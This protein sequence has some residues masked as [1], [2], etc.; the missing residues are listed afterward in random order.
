MLI[1]EKTEQEQTDFFERCF[2]KFH[3]ARTAVGVVHYDYS[4]AGRFIRLS[5]A[6][7][8]LVPLI[9]AALA[10]LQVAAD[11]SPDLTICIWDSEST[12]VKMEP[13][14]CDRDCFTDRG[15]VWGF[16][17]RKIKTAFHWIENSVNV[18][19]LDKKVGVFWVQTVASLPFWV[20]ASPLRTQFHWWMETNNLQLLHAAAVGTDQGGVLI[21]GKG[22]VGKS[23]TAL[24]CLTAGFNYAADDYL[25]V[26]ADPEP[27]AY[28]LYCT[29]KVNAEDV[30]R[31][32]QYGDAIA[33]AGSLD[34]EKAVMFLYPHLAGQLQLRMPLKAV[35]TPRITHEETTRISPAP[36]WNIQRAMAFTTMSQLPGVGRHTH[37]FINRFCAKLPFYHLFL[38]NRLDEIPGTIENFLSSSPPDEERDIQEVSISRKTPLVTAIIPVYN[39]ERFTERTLQHVVSQNYPAL[40]IIVVDDGSTDATGDIV[41]RMDMD[42]RYFRQDNQGPASARNRGL[43]DA[44]GEYIFFLDVDDYWPENNIRLLVEQIHADDHLD[45]VRGYAQLVFED[46]KTGDV[47]FGGNPKES[48]ADYIGAAVYRK[49]VFA[50]VGL[51]DPTLLFGEDSDWF[52]RARECQIPMKRIEDTTLYV[53][54]HGGNMTRGKDLV[55]LNVLHVFKKAL[56][57]RR[58]MRKQEPGR[59]HGDSRQDG[60]G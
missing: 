18:M 26:G 22:G 6:G 38:G 41:N 51:F 35:F 27:V 17:S 56:D 42:V 30:G 11:Q 9:T 10:H 37:D 49:T 40:E 19:D 14:P 45:V 21:T 48:F 36:Y 3:L 4:V 31:F 54:R 2:E 47:T 55:E 53:R 39:G 7:D 5:F 32:K 46:P 57:R 50:N 33:N 20:H 25:I 8:R 44:S 43:K 59:S 34:E 15:D 29:A 24:S 12:G 52:V 13:P 16:N 23:T 28:S 60:N 1:T 58:M